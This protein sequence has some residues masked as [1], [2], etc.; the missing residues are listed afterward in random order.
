MCYIHIKKLKKHYIL[1]V[2]KFIIINFTIKFH[3]IEHWDG[4]FIYTITLG[5]SVPLQEDYFL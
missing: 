3:I 4:A 1:L 5:W 2:W